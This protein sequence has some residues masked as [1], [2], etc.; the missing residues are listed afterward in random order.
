MSDELDMDLEFDFEREDDVLD[1]TDWDNVIMVASN[2]GNVGK[3][4]FAETFIEIVD[5]FNKKTPNRL[6]SREYYSFD[7]DHTNSIF[8][9]GNRDSKGNLIENSKQDPITGIKLL[10]I[11]EKGAFLNILSG[12]GHNKIADFPARGIDPLLQ[13]AFNGDVQAWIDT[14][15]NNKHIP[16]IVIPYVSTKCS[17]TVE[18]VTTLLSG[19][20]TNL[21][22]HIVM[23]LNKGFHKND[24]D[25]ERMY[26]E[27]ENVRELK[28]KYIF[29]EIV[30]DVQFDDTIIAKNS[31]ERI[32]QIL[33]KKLN[34]FS[35]TLLKT[36][37]IKI[38]PQLL[39]LIK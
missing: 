19:V 5:F 35:E 8:K 30:N 11:D 13:K 14:I 3:S 12:T 24:S 15:K 20:E 38:K 21:P 34:P 33:S 10:D 29:T 9:F 37:L 36:Y 23:F 6:F 2:N 26:L 32:M 27:D 7:K 17:A 28:S 22:I 18:R 16:F 25:V 39:A 4:T 1:T 31:K